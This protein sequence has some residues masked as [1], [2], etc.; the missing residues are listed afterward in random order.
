MVII[1]EGPDGTGKTTLIKE[2]CKDVNYVEL[3]GIP[4][5]YPDQFKHWSNLLSSCSM[6]SITYVIDRCFLSEIV[7]RCVKDDLYPNITFNKILEL[8]NIKHVIYILCK[9]DNAYKYATERGEEYVNENEHKL[10]TDYYNVLFTMLD[11]FTPMRM[12]E[13]D[14]TKDTVE[15]LKEDLMEIENG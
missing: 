9:T 10:I 5:N 3:K 2:L 4:R 1:V 11:K 15:R 8:L 6:S 7:Y 14:F 12:T 13:Y